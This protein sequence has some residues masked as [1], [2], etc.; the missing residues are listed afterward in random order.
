MAS[1]FRDSLTESGADHI[2]LSFPTLVPDVCNRGSSVIG[3]PGFFLFQAGHHEWR[4]RRERHCIPACA[5]KTDSCY[6]RINDTLEQFNESDHQRNNQR[7][8]GN[9]GSHHPFQQVDFGGLNI[10]LE[11]KLD[12][13]KVGFDRLDVRLER[14]NIDLGGQVAVEQLD[15]LLREGLRPVVP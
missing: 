11:T 8:L 7:A 10:R 14:Q 9:H 4:G 15:L 3:N 6:F 12:R 2:N 13:F 1:S 5:G